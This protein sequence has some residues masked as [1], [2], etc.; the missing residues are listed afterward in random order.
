[1]PD[2]AVAEF[3]A[4]LILTSYQ[5]IRP[6]DDAEFLGA[7]DHGKVHNIAD[8]VLIDAPRNCGYQ[9]QEPLKPYPS[10]LGDNFFLQ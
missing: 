2:R 6:A 9:T 4:A 5:N 3:T 7:G 10:P 1:M 8:G